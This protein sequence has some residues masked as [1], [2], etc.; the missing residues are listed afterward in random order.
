MISFAKKER[1]INSLA[2]PS[3][4][5]ILSALSASTNLAE[6]EGLLMRPIVGLTALHHT[7]SLPPPSP[8][9]LPS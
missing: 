3:N 5:T 8:L 4:F 7:H 6:E 1:L 2:P 9:Q